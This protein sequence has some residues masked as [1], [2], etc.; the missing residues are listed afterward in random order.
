MLSF[1]TTTS[2]L[3]LLALWN[4]S[5]PSWQTPPTPPADA[6]PTA[7]LDQE[8]LE[9]AFQKKLTGAVFVGRFTVDDDP[10]AAP[11]EERYTITKVSKIGGEMWLFTCRIQYGDHDLAL[12]LPLRV[13]WAGDTPVITVDSVPV[14]GLGTFNARVLVYEKQYGGT[15]SGKEQ[16]RHLFG[17]IERAQP[18]EKN[19]EN[20]EKSNSETK[21]G[22]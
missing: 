6:A 14:P 8:K 9:A 3:V 19:S 4:L 18:S 7:K 20:S 1:S 13:C 21:D 12:P 16:G 11:K 15:W 2:S 22:K 17:R 10:G 5:A